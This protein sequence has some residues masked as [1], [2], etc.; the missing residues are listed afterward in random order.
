MVSIF[1]IYNVTSIV[2]IKEGIV[3]SVDVSSNSKNHYYL[4]Y[5]QDSTF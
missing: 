5:N 2:N 3:S 4:E 1:I